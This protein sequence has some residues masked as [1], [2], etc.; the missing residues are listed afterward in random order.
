[1]RLPVDPHPPTPPPDSVRYRFS[2]L[3][4][5][6]VLLQ[7]TSARPRGSYAS[8]AVEA[9]ERRPQGPHAS[10]RPASGTSRRLSTPCGGADP[11]VFGLLR[12]EAK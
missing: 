5:L 7:K 8:G 10:G 2:L 1:M 12:N 4:F 6:A 3:D 11:D 9:M